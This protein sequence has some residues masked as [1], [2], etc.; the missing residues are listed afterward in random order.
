MTDR[1]SIGRSLAGPVL[2]ALGMALVL[3]ALW[4]PASESS[5][6]AA[7]PAQAAATLPEVTRGQALFIAKGCATCHRHAAVT[8]GRSLNVGPDLSRNAADPTFLRRW[9]QDSGA[10]RPGT[11]MPNLGLRPDEIEVLIAFLVGSTSPE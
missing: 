10:V 3:V 6:P 9:L 8:T 4:S 1:A 5:P 2:V 7:A 11:A